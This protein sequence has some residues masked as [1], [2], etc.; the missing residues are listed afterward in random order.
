MIHTLG[1]LLVLTALI[2][3][4]LNVFASATQVFAAEVITSP[5]GDPVSFS[6]RYRDK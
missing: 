1:L 5:A 4:S 3:L 6:P 2:D